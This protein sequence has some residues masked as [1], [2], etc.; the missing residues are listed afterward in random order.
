MANSFPIT[1]GRCPFYGA[2]DN[3]T[4]TQRA[5]FGTPVFKDRSTNITKK[6]FCSV[7]ADPTKDD[8]DKFLAM[9]KWR[10][11][12]LILETKTDTDMLNIYRLF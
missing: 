9:N 11:K 7:S 10:S 3:F 4:K 5:A 2:V 6:G 12:R 1:T 8:A